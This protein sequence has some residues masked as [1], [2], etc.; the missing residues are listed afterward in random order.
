M[1]SDKITCA[2]KYGC[3]GCFG[4][5]CLF[6]IGYLF[7]YIYTFNHEKCIYYIEEID[8]YILFDR[9]G[10]EDMG[11]VC[12]GKTIEDIDKKLNCFLINRTR[13]DAHSV[14][15]IKSKVNDSIFVITQSEEDMKVVSSIHYVISSLFPSRKEVTSYGLDDKVHK[16]IVI[17]QAYDNRFRDNASDYFTILYNWDCKWHKK[18]PLL[19][20]DGYNIGRRNYGKVKLLDP[21]KR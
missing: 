9:N 7:I 3:F 19:I 18:N 1:A 20:E 15:I 14:E 6:F 16:S 10:N 8:T 17:D 2:M 11:Y 5:I 21:I 13:W 4:A 12:F